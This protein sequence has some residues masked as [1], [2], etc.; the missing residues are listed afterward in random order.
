MSFDISA[1]IPQSKSEIRMLSVEG[2][3]YS[4]RFASLGLRFNQAAR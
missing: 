3:G 2:E 1:E 4:S